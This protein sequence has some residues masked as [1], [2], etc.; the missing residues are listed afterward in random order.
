MKSCS[1]KAMKTF[2]ILT[3]H[4]LWDIWAVTLF[5]HMQRQFRLSHKYLGPGSKSSQYFHPCTRFSASS[6]LFLPLPPFKANFVGEQPQ[7]FPPIFLFPFLKNFGGGG[8]LNKG[9]CWDPSLP[10]LPTP[11]MAAQVKGQ[12]AYHL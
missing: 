3:S 1:I 10:I 2:W 8:S 5:V 12:E 7:S 9:P 4:S 6:S 11:I